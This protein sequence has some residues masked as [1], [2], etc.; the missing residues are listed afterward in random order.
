MER[1][2]LPANLSLNEIVAA[3]QEDD[4]LGF[5]LKCGSEAYGVEPDAEKYTCEECEAPTVYGAEQLLLM[6][7]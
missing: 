4:N 2:M 5:C 6:Y 7:A 3:V 1:F